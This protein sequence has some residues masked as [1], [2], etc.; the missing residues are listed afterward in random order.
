MNVIRN[1]PPLKTN[2]GFT[3]VELL[4]GL[5]LSLFIAGIALTYFVS[6]SKTFRAQ[7]GESV[8]QENARFALE[9]LSMNFRLAG[10]NPSNDFA[11]SLDVIYKGTKCGSGEAGVNDNATGTA[12]CTREGT[13]GTGSS[14]NP[15]SD[16]VAIDYIVDAGSSAT[17]LTINGCNGSPITVVAGSN[18]H[19]ISNF[20]TADIDGDG[21]RSLYCQTI[22]LDTGLAEGVAQPLIDGVD[23]MQVQYGVDVDE[24]GIIERYQSL[25]N[26]GANIKKVRAI[27][28]ALLI[29]SG[30]GIETDTVTEEVVQRS[31]TLLDAP[32]ENFTD[33]QFRNIY[34]TT[35]ALPNTLL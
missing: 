3:L 32:T 1:F 30:L 24:N 27:R 21:V 35:V 16:R 29:N 15:N 14:A 5:V 12:A 8:V 22:N 28:L 17:N 20:W 23:R 19:L 4:I 13:T 7:T 34:T 6:S 9:S 26:L 18:V 31:Y 25:T 33:W 10:M 11:A 2:Q